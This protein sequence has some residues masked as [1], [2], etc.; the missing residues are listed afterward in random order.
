MKRHSD[1]HL[2]TSVEMMSVIVELSSLSSSSMG[3]G[4][5][6][7]CLRC[8]ALRICCLFCQMVSASFSHLTHTHRCNVVS[9]V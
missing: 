8:S 3:P 1:T 4:M 6:S 9:G 5:G 7:C 2:V